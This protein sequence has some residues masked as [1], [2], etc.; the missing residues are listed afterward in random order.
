[1]IKLL[2]LNLKKDHSLARLKFS[3][4]S[5]KADSYNILLDS[6]SMETLKMSTKSDLRNKNYS[7]K[8]YLMSM[9]R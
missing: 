1:M 6:S 3:E 2:H 4:K 5:E 7:S 8:Y 9:T